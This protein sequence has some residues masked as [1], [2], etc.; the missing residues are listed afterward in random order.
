MTWLVVDFGQWPTAPCMQRNVMEWLHLE[1]QHF[2]VIMLVCLAYWLERLPNRSDWSIVEMIYKK[3]RYKAWNERQKEW[4]SNW[5]REWRRRRRMG[6][7]ADVQKE[8]IEKRTSF[9]KLRQSTCRSTAL[10]LTTKH[11]DIY[12]SLSACVS[13]RRY[14]AQVCCLCRPIK[15]V[16][17]LFVSGLPMDAKP[18]EL[19]LLFQAYKVRYSISYYRVMLCVART[20]PS[21]DVRPSIR[22]SVCLSVCNTPVFCLNSWTYR[23]TFFT[24]GEPH[25]SIFSYEMVW[26]YSDGDPPS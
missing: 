17:T 6:N 16:R 7:E 4:V 20:V 18:R 3:Y 2:S 25:R 21:Q 5:Q 15:Q 14:S 19:H 13:W 1:F 8:W 9:T 26:Q 11:H 10:C 22:P 24:V 23:Q 12:S